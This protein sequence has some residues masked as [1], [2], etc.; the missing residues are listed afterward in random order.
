[1][2]MSHHSPC[3]LIGAV[4]VVATYP[5]VKNVDNSPEVVREMAELRDALQAC[6]AAN[7]SCS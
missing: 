7:P 4:L 2:S 6:E 1:M 5:N 3:S